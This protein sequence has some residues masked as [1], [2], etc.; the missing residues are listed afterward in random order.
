MS[1]LYNWIWREPRSGLAN[2]L[3]LIMTLPLAFLLIIANFYT[4]DPIYAK[5]LTFVW[6]GIVGI[7]LAEVLPSKWNPIPAALRI[8]SLICGGIAL[9]LLWWQ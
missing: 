5:V 4:P 6:I 2:W 1:Y 7:R 3:L 8:M 9:V